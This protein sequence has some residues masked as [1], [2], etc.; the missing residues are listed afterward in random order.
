V[1]NGE[2]GNRTVLKSSYLYDLGIFISELCSLFKQ[3]KGAA[4]ITDID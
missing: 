1:L 4:V 3:E 2:N